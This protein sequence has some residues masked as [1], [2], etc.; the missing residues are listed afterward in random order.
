MAEAHLELLMAG[1]M[2]EHVAAANGSLRC[3][4][5]STNGALTCQ[6]NAEIDSRQSPVCEPAE[7][8]S[9]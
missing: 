5:R 9:R 3:G 8:R 6:W 1:P 2:P 4:W 7:R